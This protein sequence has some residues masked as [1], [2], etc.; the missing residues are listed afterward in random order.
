MKPLKVIQLGNSES[1]NKKN[2]NVS[3]WHWVPHDH[4]TLW[5][6]KEDWIRE[7]IGTENEDWVWLQP[8]YAA[9]H[10]TNLTPLRYGFKRPEDAAMFAMLW[11]TP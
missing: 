1:S 7:N 3:E 11:Y 5:G 10:Q 8:E 2:I 9:D 4:K 6:P